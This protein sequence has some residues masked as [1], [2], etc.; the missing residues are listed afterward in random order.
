MGGCAHPVRVMVAVGPHDFG[1]RA[2][3]NGLERPADA[4]KLEIKIAPES[5]D[6]NMKIRFQPFALRLAYLIAPANLKD[7]KND[8]DHGQGAD[9]ANPGC[10]TA[11]AQSHSA[12]IVE[13]VSRRKRDGISLWRWRPR[14]SFFS[15][16]GIAALKL[17][18]AVRT[19][20]L[21]YRLLL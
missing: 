18:P 6:G 4:E 8:E 7:G 11:R 3:G 21:Q 10:G 15:A 14:R 20:R 1:R 12:S 17:R 2:A 9:Q 13:D 19:P 16:L 5:R